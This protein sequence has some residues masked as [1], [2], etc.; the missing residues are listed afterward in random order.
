MRILIAAA[1]LLPAPAFADMVGRSDKAARVCGRDN[2]V[3][4]AA[5]AGQGGFQRLD[6][7]PA[8]KEYL[9]VYRSIGGCPAPVI[10]RYDIGASVATPR[11]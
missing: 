6:H 1:L 4:Q 9:T 2:R 11:R 5:A 7:L 3:L 10:V 8:A